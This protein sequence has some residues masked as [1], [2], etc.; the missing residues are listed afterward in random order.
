MPELFVR[1]GRATKHI[2]PGREELKQAKAEER[3]IPIM[4]KNIMMRLASGLMVAVLLSTCAISGTYA[5]Y[6]TSG[7]STD[8]ARVAKFGV[9]VTAG[10]ELFLKNYATTDTAKFDGPNSVVSSDEWKLVAPGTSMTADQ[11]ALTGTPEVAVE[12]KHEV[13][14]LVLD[15]AKWYVDGAEYCPIIF[16]VGSNDY[17]INGSSITN[18]AGLITA[19]KDAV[20]GYS[21]VYA[22][23]TDLSGHAIPEVSW[24]WEFEGEK[25][26]ATLNGYQTDEK[27]TK[28]GNAAVVEDI[29]IKMDMKCT[30]T[31]ID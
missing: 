30:V 31:Q 20:N 14:E 13:T 11:F 5:K 21:A 3:R 6:V 7:T 10:G 16:T 12:V 28:L 2:F 15:A 19:V 4:K 18:I 26:G 29:S 17:Y 8:Q 24:R 1:E 23:G 9:E 22:P 25:L 27:D